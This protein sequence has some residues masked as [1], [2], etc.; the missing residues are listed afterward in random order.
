MYSS[1]RDQDGG[2]R[3]TDGSPVKGHMGG[4]EE[5]T[6]V[7]D[8]RAFPNTPEGDDV[9]VTPSFVSHQQPITSV[10]LHPPQD[11]IV[12]AASADSRITLL[13]LNVEMDNGESND[14]GGVD[15]IPPQLLFIHCRK[16]D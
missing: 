11:C 4:I 15:D 10:E 8:P 7:W 14:T 6:C 9:S 13:D 3:A 5:L 12:P 1:P 2:T 16:D